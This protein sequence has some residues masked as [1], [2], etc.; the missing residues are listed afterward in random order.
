MPIVPSVASEDRRAQHRADLVEAGGQAALEQDERERD[1]ADLARQLEVVE[2]DPVGPV[3]PDRHAERE[4]QHEAGHPQP[5]SRKRR[6][7]TSRQQD[8]DDQEELSLAH[9]R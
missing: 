4:D 9:G 7:Q 1:D 3:G 8:P 2:R 6:G 5:A